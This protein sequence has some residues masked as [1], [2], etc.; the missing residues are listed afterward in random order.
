MSAVLCRA[1]ADDSEPRSLVLKMY[2]I[3]LFIILTTFQTIVYDNELLS[4]DDI[5]IL[6]K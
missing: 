4:A 1:A 5:L 6:Y 2:C 3:L